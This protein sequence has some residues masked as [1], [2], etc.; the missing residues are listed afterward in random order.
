MQKSAAELKARPLL[1]FTAAEACEAM[2]RSFEEYFVPMVFDVAGF[3]RR[4]RGENL[5]AQASKLWFRADEL[6]GL[7]LIARR[8]WNSRVAAMGLVVA[9]RGKGYGKVM[10]NVAIAEARARGDRN[11]LLEVFTAN[12]RARRLYEG[13]G[14]RNTR[15]LSTF[16]CPFKP[17][18]RPG[19][20]LTEAD[21]REVARLLYQ[22]TEGELPWMLAPETMAATAPPVRAVHLAGKAFAIVRA[23]PQ[24][25]LLLTL[26]VPRQWRRQGLGTRLLRALEAQYS[27]KNLVA[28]LLPEG[29]EQA[30][31]RASGWEVQPLTLDEMMLSL[32]SETV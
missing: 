4:F 8:G 31:L 16:G 21:P 5:D 9:E 25:T 23:D 28:Y 26:I 3:E 18:S 7:V 2:N 19:A 29:P 17:T 27:E 10:L 1:E 15:R 14:F 20:E 6:V 11:L 24:R 13:L 30:F 12:E 32:V 22:E